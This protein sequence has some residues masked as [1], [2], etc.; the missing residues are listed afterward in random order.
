MLQCPPQPTFCSPSWPTSIKL[1]AD[2]LRRTV[3][4]KQGRIQNGGALP[5]NFFLPLGSRYQKVIRQFVRTVIAKST[6]ALKP[7]ITFNTKQNTARLEK[8]DFPKRYRLATFGASPISPTQDVKVHFDSPREDLKNAYLQ[9]SRS[10]SV[11]TKLALIAFWRVGRPS[12]ATP[13]IGSNF[14][15]I[16]TTTQAPQLSAKS[17]KSL[18]RIFHISTFCI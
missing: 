2:L 6:G 3:P 5:L 7:L 8:T 18:L 14:V 1:N 10:A 9:S 11:P 13:L 12:L 4:P 17:R 16:E 15:P